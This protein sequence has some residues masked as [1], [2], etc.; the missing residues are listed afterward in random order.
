MSTQIT[1]TIIIKDVEIEKVKSRAAC[2]EGNRQPIKEMDYLHN[3]FSILKEI[4]QLS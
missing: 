3:I 1:K 4:R 2:Q